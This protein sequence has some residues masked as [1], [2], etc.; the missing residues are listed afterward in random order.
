MGSEQSAGSID[1]GCPAEII[2]IFE[3]RQSP[4][5]VSDLHKAHRSP[6]FEALA[7]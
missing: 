3:L 4:N 2:I 1:L 5:D 6:D 7:L